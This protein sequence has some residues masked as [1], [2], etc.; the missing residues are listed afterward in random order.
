M[1]R[2]A[3]LRN[4]FL[5]QIAREAGDADDATVNGI[6]A[7]LGADPDDADERSLSQ[8]ALWQ[9]KK[10]ELLLVEEEPDEVEEGI[11][12]PVAEPG[13]EVMKLMKLD[14]GPEAE[15]EER[16]EKL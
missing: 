10:A 7:T 12:D 13:D 5:L 4:S 1:T 3:D 15:K 14:E 16:G 8:L 9:A 6:V 2:K 11:E